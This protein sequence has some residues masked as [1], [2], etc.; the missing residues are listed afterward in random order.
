MVS[1]S[2]RDGVCVLEIDNPPVNALSAGVAVGFAREIAA[3]EADPAVRAFVICG[4][5]GAFSGGADIRE[6]GKPMSSPNLRDTIATIEASSKRFYAAIDVIAFGGGLELALACD[7]RHATRRA[8]LGL[9]EV[10]LGLLPGGGGTQR[11][12]RLIG[13]EP[14][15]AIV[16]SG[17]PVPAERAL[18]LGIVDSV[19]DGDVV[20]H[21]CAIARAATSR[22]R[23]LL[24]N[25]VSSST[26]ETFA[27]AR[28]EALPIERGGLA[29]QRCIDAVEAST[30]RDFDAGLAREAEL[31][32]ELMASEQSISK[33]WLFF[34]ERETSKVPDVPSDTPTVPLKR[35]AVIGSGTMGGGIAMALANGGLQATII[36]VGIEQLT[37]GREI[38]ESNYAAS[39]KK[40]RFSH[41]EVQE[42]LGRLSYSTSLHG[43]HD[44][45][46][47]IEAVFEE[48]DI[49][50]EVFKELD[51]ICKQG[52]ILATNTSTLDIDA[53]AS[54]TSRPQDVIGL[55]FFSPA[56][57]MKLLE[58]VR[59]SQTS[60]SAI[61]TAFSLAKRIGKIGVLARTCDGFIG[62][63][64]LAGYTR[65]SQYLIEEGATPESVDRAIRDFGFPMGPCAM[66]DMAGL[67]VGWRVRKR[68]AAEGKYALY[69][70]SE[71][72]SQL[73]ELGRYGQ[74][75]GAGYYRYEKGDRTPHPDPAVAALIEAESARLGIARRNI[76]GDEIVERCMF[77]LINEGANVLSDGTAIRASD[78]DVV[79]VYGYGWPAFRG[80]PMRY[81]DSL[82]LAHVLARLRDLEARHGA[83][84]T[85]SP[86]IVELAERGATFADFVA[87]PAAAAR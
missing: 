10:K 86:L 24:R 1:S 79:W 28:A 31:F 2:I 76:S 84:W 17:E 60:A 6:F 43:A 45:D 15:L 20:E 70:D 82:G 48:L 29:V 54:A 49:K 26:P 32:T 64:M 80:G 22:E 83:Q 5:A 81:A 12:P 46:L 74:K 14:A 13:V 53:I 39:A 41:A 87:A 34:A 59:G 75:T 69:R 61:A 71:I 16:T 8:R 57:V 55:H 62:N 63:R 40:G 85:P 33:R 38:I 36:D 66:G 9:P 3:G 73:C 25:L 78:I 68:R 56:N 72:V 42:R 52:A 27:R 65:E 7:E 67:D 44:A 30:D 58:I 23:T 21:V 11:L 77:P 35:V 37:R 51:R 47:V 18:A 19:V 50:R 4:K